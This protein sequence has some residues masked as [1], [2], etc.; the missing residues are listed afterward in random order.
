MI[1]KPENL[2]RKKEPE[3]CNWGMGGFPT[4]PRHLRQ[5]RATEF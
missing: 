2:E 4:P 1:N 5:P 3:I